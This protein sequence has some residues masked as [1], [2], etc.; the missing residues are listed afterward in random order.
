MIL[1][2]DIGGTNTRL[3][4]FRQHGGNL[5]MLCERKYLSRQHKSLEEIVALLVAEEKVRVDAACFG[6]A[7][8]VRQGRARP[9]NL[10]WEIDVDRLAAQLGIQTVWLINDLETHASALDDLQP[11]DFIT[12]NSASALEGNVALIAA[13]TGLGQA[14]VYWDGK[15]RHV[16]PSEGGHADF[17]PRNDLEI[18]L[19][20]YLHKK[21]GHVS[22]ERVLSGPGI[23]NV[24]DFLRDSATEQEP[25]WLK[26]ELE[27]AED[28]AVPISQY[29]LEGKA[30][31]CERTLDIFVA[32]YGAEA[33]NLALRMMAVGGV[34]VSGG[35]AGKL[36]PKMQ[37]PAFMEAFVEKGR[38]K[39]LLQTV[40]VKLIINEHIGLVGAA[41]YAV[42]RMQEAAAAV[43][44][45]P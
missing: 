21:F 24:Y 18:A 6:V 14:G 42:T 35:I 27:R 20:Q 13:G 5:E 44:V 8:P 25:P 19:H 32:I 15:R 41:R 39:S 23:K 3:G 38:M 9:S 10:D 31:I 22:C 33:G 37:G 30:R 1:A 17:A 36:L 43:A 40:P 28:H 12:L 4:V 16:F 29:G 11:A 2:G 26:E 34:F 45:S 7:G